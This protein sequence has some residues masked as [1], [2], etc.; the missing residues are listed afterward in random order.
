MAPRFARGF[1]PDAYRNTEAVKLL[2]EPFYLI[3]G[4]RDDVVPADMGK[5]LFDLA[6]GKQGGA[7]VIRT[8]GHVP[9]PAD[10]R[11]IFAAIAADHA[12]QPLPALPRDI[13]AVRFPAKR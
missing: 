4:A 10:L 7:F 1:V 3:H 13:H 11:T 2:D 8:A 12:G 5:A 9:D 6:V